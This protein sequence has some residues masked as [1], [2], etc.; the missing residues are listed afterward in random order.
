MTPETAAKT[1]TAQKK[2][3]RSRRAKPF[4]VLP[5]ED[6]LALPRKIV[7]CGVDGQMNR[8]TVLDK[9]DKSPTSSATRALITASSRYGLTSGSYASPSL[10]VTEEGRLVSAAHD[11]SERTQKVFDLAIGRFGPFKTLY[12]KLKDKRLPDPSVLRDE[13]GHAGVTEADREKGVDVFVANARYMNLVQKVSGADFV[14]TIETVVDQKPS[15]RSDDEVVPPSSGQSDSGQ[16]GTRASDITN[17]TNASNGAAASEPS[18]HI[19]VQVHIDATASAE[20]I[21]Q[22]FASMAKHLYGRGE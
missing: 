16:K 3:R 1:P 17:R 2:P 4:P 13:L 10:K 18:L 8:L 12:E 21:D 7:E 5:F 9:M 11:S 19:D 15:S 20:Q 6:A 22:V 14:R